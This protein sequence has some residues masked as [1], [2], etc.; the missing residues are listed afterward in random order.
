MTQQQKLRSTLRERAESRARIPNRTHMQLRQQEQ[1]ELIQLIRDDDTGEYL[2]YRQLMRSPKHRIIWNRSS[3]N[4]FGRLAQGLKDGRVT[5]T[6]TI[7]H[8]HAQGLLAIIYRAKETGGILVCCEHG[9]ITHS[10]AKGDYWVPVDAYSVI[11]KADKDAPLPSVLQATHNQVL[12]DDFNP[13]NR[14]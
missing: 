1:R 8:S 6:N 14:P 10:G 11:A 3:A 5:G 4:E 7:T 13:K 2:N 9:V 12:G